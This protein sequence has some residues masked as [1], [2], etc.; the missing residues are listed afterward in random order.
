MEENL[1]QDSTN[2]EGLFDDVTE[3]DV[4]EDT[5]KEETTEEKVTD[6]QNVEQPKGVSEEPF[7]DIVYNKETKNLSKDEAR[8]LAQ[9]GMNY[10]HMLER[11]APIEELARLNNMDTV[12]FIKTLNETQRQFEL[13]KE[14]NSLK[15]QYPNTD[16]TVLKELAQSRAEGRVAAQK[17]KFQ[18]E[19]NEQVNAQEQQVKRDLELFKQEFPDVDYTELPQEVYE[20]VRNGLP[21]LSAYYKYLRTTE[22]VAS[23]VDKINETN[24]QKS[25]GSTTNA[26]GGTHDA[27]LEG[28]N[29]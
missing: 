24:K 3:G 16:E 18:K 13:D 10:D 2:A 17:E 6:H 12:T 9:K 20:N 21:L 28:F 15:Q 4:T 27:F 14:L 7:L 25:L 23:K 1:N 22:S 8:T 19:Q 29:S 11:Y 26:G 5:Q